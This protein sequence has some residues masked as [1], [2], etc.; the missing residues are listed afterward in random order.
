M[1]DEDTSK[2]LARQLAIANNVAKPDAGR[3]LWTFPEIAGVWLTT[4]PEE[5]RG[6]YVKVTY[7]NLPEENAD[8]AVADPVTASLSMCTEEVTAEMPVRFFFKLKG[9]RNPDDEKVPNWFYYWR[10]TAAGRGLP[11]SQVQYSPPG[12]CQDEDDAATTTFGFYTPG[13][14][15]INVC[16]PVTGSAWN[17][18]TGEFT[19]GI[20]TYAVTIL[21]EW[22]HKKHYEQWWRDFDEDWTAR[23]GGPKYEEPCVHKTCWT[24]EY[25]RARRA[26][27][28]DRDEIPDR[29][30]RSLGM[31]PKW[32]DTHRC[33]MTD[34]HY[35]A[36]LAEGLWPS[37][38]ADEEDWA[39]PGKQYGAE[40]P[41]RDAGQD[42]V[43][44]MVTERRAA[45]LW[46]GAT[47]RC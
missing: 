21:H 14:S 2:G 41:E 10:Q 17:S 24:L 33:K 9:T 6:Q 18:V 16:D 42:V 5:G 43:G 1:F 29:L 4:D 37:G 39:A 3:V 31:N 47:P 12:E 38:A 28:R 23:T 8:F 32:R 40:A 27:D 45:V 20:D 30:E 35:L 19:D 7:T 26:V 25:R 11:R 34:E 46:R 22:E 15:H 36:W 13:D 44:D